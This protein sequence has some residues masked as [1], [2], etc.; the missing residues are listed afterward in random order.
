MQ[1]P[2]TALVGMSKRRRLAGPTGLGRAELVEMTDTYVVFI[3]VVHQQS[4]FD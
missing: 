4:R 1:H 2:V 3:S